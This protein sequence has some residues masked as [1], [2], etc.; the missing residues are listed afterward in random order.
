[1][2]EDEADFTFADMPIRSIVAFKQDLSLIGELQASDDAQQGRLAAARR[3][4]QGNQFAG[5]NVDG[6]VVQRME[7]TEMLADVADG[8]THGAI[9]NT[10]CLFLLQRSIDDS[11]Y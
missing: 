9:S 10:C 2:L 7:G 4:K 5:R 6:Y 3:A 8:D 1:M 11:V